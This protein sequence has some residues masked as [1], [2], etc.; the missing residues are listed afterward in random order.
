MET[1]IE[2]ALEAW[3]YARSGGV[4]E[5]ASLGERDVAFRPAEGSRSVAELVFHILESGA[6]MAGELSRKDG[7]F[8]RKSYEALLREHGRAISRGKTRPAARCE[9]GAPIFWGSKFCAQCGRA[10]AGAPAL[11]VETP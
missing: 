5:V 7:D 2:E 9:C 8:R 1:L 6:L 10:V 11:P 3:G 4:D